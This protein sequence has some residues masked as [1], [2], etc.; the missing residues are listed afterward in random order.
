MHTDLH[1]VILDQTCHWYNSFI[2]FYFL[3]EERTKLD[4]ERAQS[5]KRTRVQSPAPL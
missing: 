1:F 2:L 3:K 4:L 5:V